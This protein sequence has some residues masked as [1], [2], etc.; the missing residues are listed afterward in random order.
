MQRR[1]EGQRSHLKR[2]LRGLNVRGKKKRK[3]RGNS[4][5]SGIC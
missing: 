5:K 1:E 4:G 3:R 2:N